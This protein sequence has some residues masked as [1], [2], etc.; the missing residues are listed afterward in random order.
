MISEF[1]A[2]V[3]TKSIAKT[4]QYVVEIFPPPHPRMAAPS[5][6]LN[7]T[8]LY[9]NSASLPGISYAT[10]SY[11]IFGEGREMPYQRMFEPITLSF[12]VDADMNIKRFFDKWSKCIM[13]T[14]TRNVSYYNSYVSTIRIKSAY[15][16]QNNVVTDDWNVVRSAEDVFPY[17]VELQEAYPKSIRSI[18]ID[19][20]QAKLMELQVTFAYKY[21]KL[22][23]DEM[24]PPLSK[25]PADVSQTIRTIPVSA[26]AGQSAALPDG[27]GMTLITGS[28][29]N[30]SSSS[31]EADF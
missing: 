26:P 23:P 4:N 13:N 15:A 10:S 22:I 29:P 1:I 18:D 5:S 16:Q 20:G 28:D 19:Y 21:W 25:A 9:C 17:V 11:H 3:K 27:T 12:Y 24:S 8:S 7:L 2:A 30:I 6:L 14:T 31:Q